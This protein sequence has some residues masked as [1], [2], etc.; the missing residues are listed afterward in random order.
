MVLFLVC[1]TVF[2]QAMYKYQDEN[3]EWI[4]TDRPPPEEQ[5]AEI[6]DLPTGPEVPTV[7]V[8]TNVFDR[9]VRFVAHNNYDVP[10]E[11]VL[12]VVTPPTITVSS[13]FNR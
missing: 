10:V 12:A 9:Q 4:F 13:G 5:V 11:V 2:A 6:L 3:G 8:T 1:S 7:T